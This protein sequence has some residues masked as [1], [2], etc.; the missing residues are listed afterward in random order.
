MKPAPSPFIELENIEYFRFEEDFVEKNVRC[1]PM[2][3]RF[4][5]DEVCIK[6][7]LSEWSKFSVEERIELAVMSCDNR[8]EATAF[9]SYLVQLITK[10]TRSEPSAMEYNIAP[11]WANATALP[12]VLLEKLLEF[13][14]VVSTE[15]WAALSN[16]QRFAL[17]KLCK[18]G[19][20]N[21]NLPKALKEFGLG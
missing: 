1:I 17:L 18:S 14:L 9:K 2:I 20:E 15:Q 3:V 12:Q 10:Y 6:L 4:K 19:H 7:K 13:D 8:E 16:L 11:D 21:K 5:M